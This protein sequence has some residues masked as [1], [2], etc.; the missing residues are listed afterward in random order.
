MEI[1]PLLL[2][3]LP[4]KQK[5]EALKRES[6]KY[7]KKMDEF[8]TL[9]TNVKKGHQTPAAKVLNLKSTKQ[10]PS[11]PVQNEKSKNKKKVTQFIT[12]SVQNQSFT[13]AFT[14]D[15]SSRIDDSL[16][17]LSNRHSQPIQQPQANSSL[18]SIDWFFKNNEDGSG[19]TFTLGTSNEEQQANEAGPSNSRKKS[20]KKLLLRYG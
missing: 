11:L 15:Y 7:L 14:K 4:D 19:E 3:T 18:N 6:E 16:Q 9:P 10:F 17:N 8:P 20:K 5:R 13:E 12:D 2:E 1:F